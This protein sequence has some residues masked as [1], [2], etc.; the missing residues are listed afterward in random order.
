MADAHAPVP[1][2]HEDDVDKPPPPHEHGGPGGGGPGEGGDRS[3]HGGHG[4]HGNGGGHG[5]GGGHGGKRPKPAP[6][7]PE[8]HAGFA[9]MAAAV[10]VVIGLVVMFTGHLFGGKLGLDDASW[11]KLTGN[12]QLAARLTSPVLVLGVVLVL[13]GA[14]MA[15]VEWRGRFKKAAPDVVAEGPAADVAKVVA[16]VGKLQGAALLIVSGALMLIAS[17]WVAQ[18]AAKPATST[19]VAPA[20]TPAT[21]H[22]H[23]K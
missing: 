20:S 4:G 19:P 10:A 2:P 5:R 21:H 13:A 14:W 18:S 15:V 22:H 11:A 8:F 17:A 12:G 7:R 16:A 1:H 23:N 3:G 6:D 9:G